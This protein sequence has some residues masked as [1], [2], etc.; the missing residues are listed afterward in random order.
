MALTVMDTLVHILM[1]SCLPSPKSGVGPK[2]SWGI[3][4]GE[5]SVNWEHRKRL[6]MRILDGIRVK[7]NK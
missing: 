2:E 7:P 3:V 1:S 5:S 4:G 6:F